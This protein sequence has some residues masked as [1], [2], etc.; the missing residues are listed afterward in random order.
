MA[1]HPGEIGIRGTDDPV[2][3]QDDADRGFVKGKCG[4]VQCNDPVKLRY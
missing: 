4:E 3:G 2:F 1:G